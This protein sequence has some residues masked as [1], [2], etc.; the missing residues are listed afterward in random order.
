MS[1]E[2]CCPKCKIIFKYPSL[3][4][5]HF[6]KAYH[7]LL[8][9]DEIETFF[10]IN[11]TYE[12]LI[13]KKKYNNIK[14]LTRHSKE[15]ICSKR[16][17]PQSIKSTNSTNSNILEALTPEQLK[18]IAKIINKKLT[19]SE[20][21]NISNISNTDN[22]T[23]TTNNMINS[24]N[25]T[26]NTIIQHINPFGF[27]D[28]RT[29]PISE[30]KMILNSGTEAGIH[31]IK[32]I[33]NKIEN[34]N[35]YKPNISRSEIACL[36][37]DFKL[38]IYK[39]KEL[40]DALFDRCIAFLHHMLYLCKQ[41]FTKNSIKYIYDNI[42]YIETTMR[43]EIYDK[44]LQNIIETEFRNNNIDT[45]DRI[46]NFIKQTK[47]ETDIKDNSILQIKN[48]LELKEETNNELKK[49]I[50]N[51]EINKLFGDPK[52]ILG[53]KKEE[54][55]LNLRISRFEESMFYNF[56]KDRIKIIKNYIMTHKKSTIGDII[57]LTK[58]ESK[59]N[60]MLDIIKTR[61]DN[62]RG[63]EYI[64][65]NI[66]DEFKL[67]DFEMEEDEYEYEYED[68]NR[69]DDNNNVSRNTDLIELNTF[70]NL[71]SI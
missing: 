33:Y 28:V 25:V 62:I 13:C 64:D 45:K 58:E 1:K 60:A 19:K 50:K 18:Q 37:N 41:E 20:I 7:C 52:V 56:W 14:T 10:K 6:R 39:G 59:I 26:N 4:K 35:F 40:C 22:T 29:I 61:V 63:Y 49:S 54:I 9:E 53:L 3:L 31:I 57:N 71:V 70:A 65:L 55:I 51:E 30:M 5:T 46:K 67:N 42:E 11:N 43:T 17:T 12:C 24:N 15:T 44:K 38:T 66:N 47:I 8:T 48:T 16:Q 36:N 21:S 32:T 23:N 27:E 34:K 68:E 69:C 2:H